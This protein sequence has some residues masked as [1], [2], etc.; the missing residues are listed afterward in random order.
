MYTFLP[1]GLNI[2]S[3]D[4]D[5]FPEL[6]EPP[7]KP[8]GKKKGKK[9]KQPT[10]DENEVP[11]SA[12]DGA[13]AVKGSKKKKQKQ[14]NNNNNNNNN[15]HVTILEQDEDYDMLEDLEPVLEKPKKT[16]STK[17]SKNE[18]PFIKPDP[19][20]AKKK[21]AKP[22]DDGDLFRNEGEPPI[23]LTFKS[24]DITHIS[25]VKKEATKG[26]EKVI[27]SKLQR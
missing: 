23:V 2:S 26:H 27:S 14:N 12:T 6:D 25:P 9:R 22:R 17:P 1:I 3:E 18:E 20:P 16:K 4:Y 10:P 24:S 15:D 21:K 5:H 13:K 7:P 11:A 8:E 19:P